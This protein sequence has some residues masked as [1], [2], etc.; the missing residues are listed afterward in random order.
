MKVSDL[1]IVTRLGIAFGV[2]W[3]TALVAVVTGWP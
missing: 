1:K 3:V 2:L